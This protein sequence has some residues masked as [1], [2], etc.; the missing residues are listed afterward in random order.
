MKESKT[1]KSLIWVKDYVRR[2]MKMYKRLLSYYRY[3]HHDGR[4]AERDQG[5]TCFFEQWQNVVPHRFKNDKRLAQRIGDLLKFSLLT[6]SVRDIRMSLDPMDRA[7]ITK[8]DNYRHSL[9]KQVK[10]YHGV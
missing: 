9:Q 10:L 2:I 8:T 7:T 4:L 3:N 1:K 6:Y 5:K